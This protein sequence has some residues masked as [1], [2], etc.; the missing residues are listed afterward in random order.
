[1]SRL[2]R[3]NVRKSIHIIYLIIN[4]IR[5]VTEAKKKKK[6]YDKIKINSDFEVKFSVEIKRTSSYYI[7]NIYQKQRANMRINSEKL[8]FLA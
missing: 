3:F 5:E 7:K 1:M 2:V 8:E 4:Q 6:G